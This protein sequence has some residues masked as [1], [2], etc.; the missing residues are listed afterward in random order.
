LRE[1]K[2]NRI[3]MP[4]RSTLLEFLDF[5]VYRGNPS[6][7]SIIM[8]RGAIDKRRSNEHSPLRVFPINFTYE[9]DSNGVILV[10]REH[11]KRGI[12]AYRGSQGYFHPCFAK[13]NGQVGIDLSDAAATRWLERRAELANFDTSD[14]TVK[15]LSSLSHT[16]IHEIYK[17]SS[18]DV[19]KNLDSNFQ[20]ALLG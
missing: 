11:E 15:L 14:F 7:M 2:D 3:V 13:E 19:M 17:V 9:I 5:A 18:S 10:A 20:Y 8:T 1:N 6:S 4:N 16:G 12:E